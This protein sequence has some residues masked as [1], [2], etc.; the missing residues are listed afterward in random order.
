MDDRS[1]YH[2]Q[3]CREDIALEF[4]CPC[5]SLGKPSDYPMSSGG[6]LFDEFFS[7]LKVHRAGRE[8]LFNQMRE[9]YDWG[10]I[11][12]CEVI[13]AELKRLIQEHKDDSDRVEGDKGLLEQ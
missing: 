13:E 6:N 8:H 2:C 9:K 4:T 5:C 11:K 7:W 3:H 10:Y 1:Y 12:A